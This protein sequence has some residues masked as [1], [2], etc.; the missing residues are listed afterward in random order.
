MDKKAIANLQEGDLIVEKVSNYTLE[1]LA[2]DFRGW[3]SRRLNRRFGSTGS[4][5]NEIELGYEIVMGVGFKD[6]EPVGT[7]TIEANG[8]ARIISSNKESRYSSNLPIE[9]YKPF[10]RKIA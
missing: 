2:D 6:Y 3:A 10:Q 4:A 5:I 8:V 1:Q 7:V 9:E